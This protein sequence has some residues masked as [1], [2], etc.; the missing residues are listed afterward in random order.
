LPAPKSRR[1]N[2]Q[3]S[4]PVNP[5][6]AAWFASLPPAIQRKQFTPEEQVLLANER[7]SIILDVADELLQKQAAETQRESPIHR[8]HSLYSLPSSDTSSQF[9]FHAPAEEKSTKMA[10]QQYMDTLSWLDDK[11]LDLQLDDYHTVIAETAQRQAQ[12]PGRRSFRNMSL[13]NISLR[14]STLSTPTKTLK[15]RSPSVYFNSTAHL[16]TS[17]PRPSFTHAP[18]ASVSSIDPA[19]AH[20]QDPAARMK[21]RL[22]LANASKFDEAVEF[23]FPSVAD[24]TSRER[25]KTSPRMQ[26]DS[27]RSFFT[28][29]TPSLAADDG[30]SDGEMQADPRTPQSTE[31]RHALPRSQKSSVD[32]ASFKQHVVRTDQYAHHTTFDREMTIRMTLTR[33]DLRSPNDMRPSSSH[34]N[35]LPLEQVPLPPIEQS[36]SIWD[37]LPSPAESTVKKLWRRIKL[38]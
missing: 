37:S 8:P 36:A 7:H 16:T 27:G 22:Y 38:I 25:P 26:S 9:S 19:A 35:A 3:T 2:R 18:K 17:L 11:D 28:D 24:R 23:G 12:T 29:D 32:R 30:S 14:Q 6:T 34:I 31:F 4:L 5:D 21:L 13:S 20:Y 33:P 1:R 15:T 10:S